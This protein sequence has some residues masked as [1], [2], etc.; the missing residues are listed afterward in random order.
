VV[1]PPGPQ[2]R[3]SPQLIEPGD[4][5]QVQVMTPV[6][7]RTWDLQVIYGDGTI[8]NIYADEFIDVTDLTPNVWTTV[9]PP[10]DDTWMREGTHAEERTYIVLETTDYWNSIRT[11]TA[12]FLIQSSNKFVLDRNVFR[13]AQDDFIQLNYKLS[14]NRDAKIIIYDLAGGFVREVVRGPRLAGWNSC[15]WDGTNEQGCRMGSGV[16]LAVILSGSY[17]KSLKFMIVR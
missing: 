11:D 15:I 13:P 9:L 6:F 2:I 4:S 17:H 10:F 7:A 12:S 14:T 3:I 8:E 5:I 16:Y 1:M